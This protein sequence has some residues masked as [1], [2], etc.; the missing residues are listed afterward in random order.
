MWHLTGG[1]GWERLRALTGITFVQIFI[2]FP[3]LRWIGG[4]LSIDGWPQKEFDERMMFKQDTA[5]QTWWP[6]LVHLCLLWTGPSALFFSLWVI[7]SRN[8]LNGIL[9]FDGCQDL[10]PP[11]HLSTTPDAN[12]ALLPCYFL[13]ACLHLGNSIIS[14][15]QFRA[16]LHNRRTRFKFGYIHLVH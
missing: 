16:L 7:L 15:S 9:S 12:F 8:K 11:S 1:D 2:L 14:L 5:K 10:T 4:L 3:M 13:L 6:Y